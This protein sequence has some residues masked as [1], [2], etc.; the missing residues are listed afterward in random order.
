MDTDRNLLFGALTVQASLVDDGQWTEACAA[1]AAG[2]A[3]TLADV[4]VDR[5]LISRDDR[6]AVERALGYKV[7]EHGGDVSAT[8][9]ATLVAP[10]SPAET[11]GDDPAARGTMTMG[12]DRPGHVVLSAIGVAPGSRE[13]YT[14]TRL[15]ATGGIGRVWLARD[16]SFGREVALKEIRPEREGN[17]I[18]CSRFLDEARITGQLEPR[19][20]VPVYELAPGDDGSGP[21]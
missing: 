21:F 1:W 10:P 4:M 6:A 11:A 12:P 15:H 8:L 19:G 7:E 16:A 9:A 13:R 2:E 17:D 18:I 5:G 3:A 20:I 14:R